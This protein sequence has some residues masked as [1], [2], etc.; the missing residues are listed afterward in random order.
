MSNQAVVYLDQNFEVQFKLNITTEPGS[1]WHITLASADT[2]QFLINLGEAAKFLQLK[3]LV[4]K[5]VAVCTN[6]HQPYTVYPLYDSSR[7]EGLRFNT[8]TVISFRDNDSDLPFMSD[9]ARLN[10]LE[11]DYRVP[12]DIESDIVE[13]F[14]QFNEI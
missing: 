11:T 6:E 14:R 2:A 12:F 10:M 1:R 5:F 7:F 3:L 8:T 4:H 9:I 13:H